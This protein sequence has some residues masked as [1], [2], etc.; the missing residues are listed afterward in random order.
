MRHLAHRL[1]RNVGPT[2][3]RCAS[4]REV[5]H[6]PWLLLAGAV[7]TFAV[8]VA[9]MLLDSAAVG[10]IALLGPWFVVLFN[11]RRD[12]MNRLAARMRRSE[13][14]VAVS[15][16][17]S[18]VGNRFAAHSTRPP[19]RSAEGRLAVGDRGWCGRGV[20][21]HSAR[22]AH[23]GGQTAA[24]RR[25]TPARG[26]LRRL[27]AVSSA[28][29]CPPSGGRRSPCRFRGA[30]PA[31]G[32]GPSPPAAESSPCDADA[33]Q[34]PEWL[35]PHPRQA[36]SPRPRQACATTTPISSVTGPCFA[37][38]ITQIRSAT[39]S[40]SLNSSKACTRR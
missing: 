9:L 20:R 19:L 10:S 1:G 11:W 14:G 40:G 32:S 29:A 22:G 12:A 17:L 27:T 26:D 25:A 13:A 5:R 2:L 4:L 6:F 37:P 18:L 15:S 31:A 3:S 38:S 34:A 21:R 36:V 35:R 28:G 7:T 16:T 24:R 23:S 8:L 39:A 33:G 30:A